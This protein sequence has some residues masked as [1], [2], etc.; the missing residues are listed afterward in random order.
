MAQQYNPAPEVTGSAGMGW[1][2]RRF[3]DGDLHQTDCRC[4]RE[5]KC[6]KFPTG[7]IIEVTRGND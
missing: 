3:W 4:S 2:E 1:L 5:K 6:R 7:I